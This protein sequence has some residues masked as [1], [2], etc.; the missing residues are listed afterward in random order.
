MKMSFS[1]ATSATSRKSQRLSMAPG[2]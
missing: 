2:L 1:S